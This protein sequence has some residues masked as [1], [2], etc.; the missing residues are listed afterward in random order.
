MKG[1]T[2][3]EGIKKSSFM[4]NAFYLARAE[5][6]LSKKQSASSNKQQPTLKLIN[7]IYDNIMIDEQTKKKAS[8]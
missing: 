1:I 4:E 3:T 5:F 7:E 2:A 6:Y 8:R